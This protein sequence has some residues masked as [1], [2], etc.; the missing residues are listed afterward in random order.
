M[1]IHEIKCLIS[2]GHSVHLLVPSSGP[3]NDEVA[4][5]GSEVQISVHPKL[6]VL[7]RSNLTHILR[8]P[9]LPHA[10]RTADVVVLWTLAVSAYVPLLRLTRRKFYVAV[11]ELLEDRRA[12]LFFAMLLV[13]S[14]PLTTC[15][16]ATSAW[17]RSLGVRES[18]IS[19]TYPVINIPAQRNHRDT[20]LAVSENA[21]QTF[22]VAV[23]GRVNGHKG[24]LE[25]VEAFGQPSMSDP[26]WRLVLAGAPFPGQ[27]SALDDVL[28]LA[29]MDSR[30]SYLGELRSMEELGDAVDLT[31]VFPT[32][33]EPFGLVPIEAWS[34]GIRSVGYGDG[35]AAEV[36]PM[37]GGTAIERGAAPAAAIASALVVERRTWELKPDLPPVDEVAS[38]LS[39]ENRV[40]SLS[41]VLAA[42]RSGAA[43]D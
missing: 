39:F 31:A 43:S 42:L 16:K 33:P 7:R 35:G 27:E 29:S 3:L 23:F 41:G 2:L 9:R 25:V 26:D 38:K 11:H 6:L 34:F 17:L 5:L 18:R 40:N 36:L 1:L 20:V 15:S 28:Q 30:I 14:F 22:T 10:M 21:R 13:G 19:V 37:V 32:K 24:H 4:G 8:S 12:R